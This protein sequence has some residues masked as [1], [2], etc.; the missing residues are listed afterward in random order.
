MFRRF[1]PAAPSSEGDHFAV[2]ALAALPEMSAA[3]VQGHFMLYKMDPAGAICNV[4]KINEW[5]HK[6]KDWD[7]NWEMEMHLHDDGHAPDIEVC[8]ALTGKQLPSIFCVPV[9]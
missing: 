9:P 3:Q 1:Y 2:T 8:W 5:W 4:D 6:E 7:Y